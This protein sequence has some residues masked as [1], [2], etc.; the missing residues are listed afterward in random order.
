MPHPAGSDRGQIVQSCSP[1]LFLLQTLLDLFI[2]ANN[3]EPP[4]GL[5]FTLK[6]CNSCHGLWG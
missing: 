4:D 3:A 2:V 1:L 5:V 6:D